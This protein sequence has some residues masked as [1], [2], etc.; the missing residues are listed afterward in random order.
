MSLR[1]AG[2]AVTVSELGKVQRTSGMTHV[3]EGHAPRRRLDAEVVVPENH[4]DEQ[5]VMSAGCSVRLSSL[6]R[7]EELEEVDRDLAPVPWPDDEDLGR[8][9]DERDEA[10]GADDPGVS[11]AERVSSPSGLGPVHSD[12]LLVD[13]GSSKREEKE[14]AK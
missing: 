9:A 8:V 1:R 10:D 14:D 3:S 7:D 12:G 13:L 11:F 4:S 2:Q 6:E 5:T